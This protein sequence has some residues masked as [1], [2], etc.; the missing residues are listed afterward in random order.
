[1][2]DEEHARNNPELF[3]KK[4][5]AGAPEKTPYTT[6]L[7]GLSEVTKAALQAAA[8]PVPGLDVKFFP[9][10]DALAIGWGKKDI[11]NGTSAGGGTPAKSRVG[12]VNA[13]VSP[14]KQSPAVNAV[15]K[16]GAKAKAGAAASG[17]ATGKTRGRPRKTEKTPAKT[18]GSKRKAAAAAAAPA[19]SKRQKK[20]PAASMVG[21]YEVK[22]PGIEQE[23]PS[24]CE[25]GL[26]LYISTTG[27][28]GV[29]VGEFDFGVLE[30]VMFI[31]TDKEAISWYSRQIDKENSY[32]RNK[33]GMG[34][35]DSE[36]ED[37]SESEGES[38]APAGTARS[39][40]KGAKATTAAKAEAPPPL[41][42]HLCWRGRETGEGQIQS[43]S[44]GEIKFTNSMFEKFTSQINL[45]FA[46]GCKLIGTK[47]STGDPSV[48]PTQWAEYSEEQYEHERVSRWGGSRW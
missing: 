33:Y 11:W 37:E 21:S 47:T 15:A 7:C 28:D 9:A 36:D 10:N 46:G 44:W 38:E 17:T 25:D 4:R 45:S 48:S 5:F 16:G 12:P 2:S 14:V 8:A 24:E 39:G 27:Q 32:S 22:C 41:K 20:T 1:M 43:D 6:L 42:Y 30:G 3:I 23:W 29:Y 18:A 26:G 31:S 13:S 40:K 34:D 19:S 35:D